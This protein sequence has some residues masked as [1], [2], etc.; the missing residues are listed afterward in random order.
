MLS[1]IKYAL[2]LYF[3]SAL[4]TRFNFLHLTAMQGLASKNSD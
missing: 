1:I 4:K 3:P 2:N